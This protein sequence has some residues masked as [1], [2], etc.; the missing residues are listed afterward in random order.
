MM[1]FKQSVITALLTWI[2]EGMD[3]NIWKHDILVFTCFDGQ[4]IL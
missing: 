4:I 1:M 2:I 3:R